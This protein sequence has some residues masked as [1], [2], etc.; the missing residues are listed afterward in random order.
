[1]KEF[2][3]GYVSAVR[4]SPGPQKGYLDR[5]VNPER[6]GEIESRNESLDVTFGAKYL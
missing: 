6:E 4:G 3:H 2:L 1:M 5:T